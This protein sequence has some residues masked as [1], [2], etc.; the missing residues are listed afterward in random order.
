MS[1]E[2]VELAERFR[3]ALEAAVRTGDLEA[4]FTLLSP[5]VEWVT[6]QR[7]LRGIEEVRQQLNWI[8]PSEAFD[9]EFS[10]EDWVDHGDGRLVCRVHEIYRLKQSGEFAYERDRRVELATRA[11]RIT[12]YEMRNVD[13][14]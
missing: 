1:A 6:P 2:D 7:T 14:G 4:V 12:R 9:Y 5:D 10:E 3:Q 13:S 8:S 11:G